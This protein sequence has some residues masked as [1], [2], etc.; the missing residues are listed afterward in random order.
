MPWVVCVC[1]AT[2]AAVAVAA[3]LRAQDGEADGS[4][5]WQQEQQHA[6]TATRGGTK[7]GRRSPQ[8]PI[9]Q[10]VPPEHCGGVQV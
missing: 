10:D 4:H 5:G 7:R 3:R 6:G 2:S 1:A 9:L 8:E